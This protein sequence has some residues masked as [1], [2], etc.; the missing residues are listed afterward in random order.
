LQLKS[1]RK[2][3]HQNGGVILDPASKA[4]SVMDLFVQNKQLGIVHPSVRMFK[5]APLFKETKYGIS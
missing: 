4:L 2:C 5:A 1:P 3:G